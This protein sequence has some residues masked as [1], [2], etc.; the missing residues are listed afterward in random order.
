MNIDS[1]VATLRESGSSLEI[2][3]PINLTKFMGLK[4]GD[5]IKVLIKKTK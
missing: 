3:I 1:F 4:V 2:T 5:K